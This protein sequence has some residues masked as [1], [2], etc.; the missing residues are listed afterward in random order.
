MFLIEEE[1]DPGSY[2]D[3]LPLLPSNEQP[4]GPYDTTDIS[5]EP[6]HYTDSFQP[7]DE[8]SPSDGSNRRRSSL[9]T[10]TEVVLPTLVVA[11]PAVAI[12]ATITL[13]K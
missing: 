12:M 13:N 5:S 9:Q 3:D 4:L 1:L 7:R 8:D 6:S 11:L 10:V 2:D